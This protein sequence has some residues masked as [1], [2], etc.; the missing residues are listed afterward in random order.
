MVFEA[1]EAVSGNM[2]NAEPSN[3]CTL[4]QVEEYSKFWDVDQ[5][6]K[7]ISEVNKRDPKSTTTLDCIELLTDMTLPGHKI[8][9]VRVFAVM[10]V[11]NKGPILSTADPHLDLFARQ[12]FTLQTPVGT[13][14][15]SILSMNNIDEELM[16][17]LSE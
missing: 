8:D 10:C 14:S 7:M 16:K 15:S 2:S 17:L 4:N 1:F 13:T 9:P 6:E 11:L 3:D 5:I 12:E